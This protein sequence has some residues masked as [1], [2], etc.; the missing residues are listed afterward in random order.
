MVSG[1]TY[2]QGRSAHEGQGD[3]SRGGLSGA[4]VEV[5]EAP[6]IAT[7]TQFD[8]LARDRNLNPHP[9]GTS[10]VLTSPP[11]QPTSTIGAR[12]HDDL[13]SDVRKKRG[14]CG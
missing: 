12:T 7:Q 11:P 14:T 2:A 3:I 4:H 8:I 10:R 6:N 9:E 1:Q 13:T 5:T